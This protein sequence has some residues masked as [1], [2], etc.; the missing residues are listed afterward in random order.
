VGTRGLSKKI[1]SKFFLESTYFKLFSYVSVDGLKKT[2]PIRRKMIRVTGSVALMRAWF[3]SLFPHR[4]DLSAALVVLGLLG[5][6]AQ[7]VR[8]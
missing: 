7:V 6:R 8:E 1:Y 2:L 4:W 3:A 5:E